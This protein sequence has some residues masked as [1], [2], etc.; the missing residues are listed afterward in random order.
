MALESHKRDSLIIIGT[1]FMVYLLQFFYTVP[2]L[3]HIKWKGQPF[4]YDPQVIAA[5][6]Y[7]DYV[8]KAASIIIIYVSLFIIL[9]K[10]REELLII[11]MFFAGYL[12][13]Y[14]LIYN[15]PVGWVHVPVPFTK[16][17]LPVPI[18]FST[19]ALSCLI[20]L[21]ARRFLIKW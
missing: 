16:Q 10:H 21:F 9:P 6:T 20:G 4:P 15:N 5:P 11:A 2:I 18:G 13:E 17:Q 14:F 3:A 8:A 19:F 1:A 7:I 12:V